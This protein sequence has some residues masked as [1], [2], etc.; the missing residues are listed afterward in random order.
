M[1]MKVQRRLI[2]PRFLE[3]H[4]IRSNTFLTERLGSIS[5]N[6]YNSVNFIVNSVH[7]ISAEA[8]DRNITTYNIEKILP[9]TSGTSVNLFFIH[10]RTLSNLPCLVIITPT[11]VNLNSLF[12]VIS[13]TVNKIKINLWLTAPKGATP[14][15]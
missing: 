7:L 2:Q 3:F 15:N 9:A 10:P 8:C 5:L 1:N 14:V 13:V 4:Q 12:K 6:F 11:I